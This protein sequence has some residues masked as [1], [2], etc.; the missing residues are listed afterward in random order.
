MKNDTVQGRR[1]GKLVE[2]SVPDRISTLLEAWGTASGL[3]GSDV[4]LWELDTDDSAV[5]AM[6]DDVLM[7][8]LTRFAPI[9]HPKDRMTRLEAAVT[10]LEDFQKGGR[11]VAEELASETSSVPGVDHSLVRAQ[12]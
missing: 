11:S 4:K 5:S 1:G 10:E 8:H 12:Y 3:K 2:V 9:P 6:P 7:T